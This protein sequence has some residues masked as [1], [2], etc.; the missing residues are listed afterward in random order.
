MCETLVFD[1]LFLQLLA[2]LFE[3]GT[4]RQLSRNHLDLLE[5]IRDHLKFRPGTLPCK[6]CTYGLCQLLVLLLDQLYLPLERH[7][8][9]QLGLLRLLK[10]HAKCL[11]F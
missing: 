5:D 9:H 10:V 11:N 3:L 8:G 1:Q 6:I 2:I 4:L 7:Q